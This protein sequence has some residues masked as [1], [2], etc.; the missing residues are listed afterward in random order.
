LGLAIVEKIITA[1]GAISTLKKK[2]TVVA[3]LLSKSQKFR[4]DLRL[5]TALF[6][7]ILLYL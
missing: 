1:H 6:K 3:S 4:L 2:K 5:E 7:Y